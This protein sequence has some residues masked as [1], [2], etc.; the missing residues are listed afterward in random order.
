MTMSQKTLNSSLGINV[1]GFVKGEFGIGEGMRANLR[2]LEAA[3]IPFAINNF[4]IDWHRNLDATYREQ[5]LVKDNPYP[6]NLVNFNPDGIAT[7]LESWGSNYFENRYNIGFWAWELP[8]FPPELQFGFNYFDEIWTFSNHAVEAI[9]AVSPIPVIKVMP[10]LVF[11][12]ASLGREAL[13]LP[14][15]KFIF[16]FMFDSLSTFERKNPGAVV[17]AFIQAFGKFDRDVCLVIKFSNSQHYPRQRDEFKALAAQYPSVRLIEGHLMREEVNALV[18]NCDCYVSLHRAEGFGLTMAEAM[19]WGKPTI[20]T[21][22]S[23]NIEFMNVGNSFLVKYDLVTVAEDIGPYKKGNIWANPDIDHAAALM[24]YVFHNY[25]QAKLV[26]ARAARETQSLL[27]P[28]TIGKQI[29]NRLEN[30]IPAK[31]ESKNDLQRQKEDL[32]Q[33]RDN[34]C[35]ERDNLLREIDWLECQ[36]QAWKNT[37]HAVQMEVEKLQSKLK[38]TEAEIE[39]WQSLIERKEHLR[40]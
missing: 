15:D 18:Y 36:S 2:S 29:R 23:S 38:K 4:H 33:E 34:L 11:P 27:N 30:I 31:I 17:E 1:A 24:H 26:G 10:S 5:D 28:Q 21:A 35:Q 13:G 25:Q 14:K 37:A 40:V 39:H 7:F 32:R 19:Y 12:P 16:L 3:R 22:Y 20:A 8:A 9:S 6:V